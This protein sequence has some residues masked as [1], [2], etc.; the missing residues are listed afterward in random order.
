MI[1]IPA[2]DCK[3]LGQELEGWSDLIGTNMENI[4]YHEL[5]RVAL[6]QGTEAPKLLWERYPLL[7]QL[8]VAACPS[9]CM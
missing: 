5:Y 6:K 3:D 8:S 2:T 9:V 4:T 7:W 1:F